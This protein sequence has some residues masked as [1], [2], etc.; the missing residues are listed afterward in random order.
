MI[1][2]RE[3]ERKR[4]KMNENVETEQDQFFLTIE[5]KRTKLTVHKQ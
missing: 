4:W 3:N 5:K 1:V 2:Q